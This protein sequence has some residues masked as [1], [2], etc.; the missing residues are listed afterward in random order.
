MKGFILT[1]SLILNNPRIIVQ[2]SA[3]LTSTTS[4]LANQTKMNNYKKI[5]E[6][7]DISSSEDEG[8]LLERASTALS[9]SY[10]P[11][12][13]IVLNMSHSSTEAAADEEEYLDISTDSLES[14]CKK[15]KLNSS[16]DTLNT[17]SQISDTHQNKLRGEGLPDSPESP[18]E[19][20]SSDVFVVEEPS[21]QEGSVTSSRVLEYLE[22]VNQEDAHSYFETPPGTP[23]RINFAP[24]SSLNDL[25]EP[26]GTIATTA[27][28]PEYYPVSFFPRLPGRGVFIR[29][30]ALSQ[31]AP[32]LGCCC[33]RIGFGRGHGCNLRFPKWYFNY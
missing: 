25:E 19:S 20:F 8:E 18:D 10:A 29:G 3:D 28:E 4:S 30:A 12:Y 2:Q 5:F 16:L 21:T 26:R 22:Q 6:L 33:K 1:F 24:A 27:P 14:D 15:L 17:Q 31:T 23:K 11:N 7:I 9:R 32:G 13:R